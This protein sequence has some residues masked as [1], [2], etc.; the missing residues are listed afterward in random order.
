MFVVYP[1]ADI[2]SLLLYLCSL[3]QKLLFDIDAP[4]VFLF[5]SLITYS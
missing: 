4:I 2:S 1:T 3:K 5:L